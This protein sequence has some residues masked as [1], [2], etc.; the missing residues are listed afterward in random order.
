METSVLLRHQIIKNLIEQTSE[1]PANILINLWKKMATQIISIIGE[2]GFN[3]LYVRS[4]FLAQSKLPWILDGLPPTETDYLFNALKLSI[5]GQV[6]AIAREASCL[7]L[8]T[9]T[10]I[11]ATLIGEQLTVSILRSAWGDDVLYNK[12][13][14]INNE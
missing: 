3:S 1:E 14:E 7:L 4:V 6:P 11:L 2:G 9:F 13:K 5:E 12:D 10:D 8:I